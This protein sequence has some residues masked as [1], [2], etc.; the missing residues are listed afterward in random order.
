MVKMKDW[1]Q[2]QGQEEEG[3]LQPWRLFSFP[4][5]SLQSI[6]AAAEQ[7]TGPAAWN[8]TSDERM[9][10]EEDEN[11][12][13]RIVSFSSSFPFDDIDGDFEYY[14]QKEERLKELYLKFNTSL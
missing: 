1:Y 11:E 4:F 2:D 12:K 6:G 10:E 9:M 3:G 8:G 7:Q 5:S 14:Y 13:K